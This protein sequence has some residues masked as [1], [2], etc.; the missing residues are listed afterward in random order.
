MSG[1]KQDNTIPKH[2]ILRQMDAQSFLPALLEVVEQG[3]D[4][5]LLISGSSMTPFLVHGRDT[6]LISPIRRSLRRGDMVLYRRANGYYV[7]HRIW[8]VRQTNGA[9]V[10]YFVGDA[11]TEIEGPLQREQLLGHITAVCRKGTWLNPGSLWWEFFEH[12]WL[13]LRPVR[14]VIRK[15]YGVCFSRKSSGEN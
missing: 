1:C 2:S 10:Y 4:V 13:W 7:M 5:P 14:P 15:V 9:K 3:Q 6:I 8:R 11:Q 12:M